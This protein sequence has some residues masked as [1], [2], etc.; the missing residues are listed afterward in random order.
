[1]TVITQLLSKDEQDLVQKAQKLAPKTSVGRELINNLL[2]RLENRGN[3]MVE[4]DGHYLKK[5]RVALPSNA[6]NP[7][8]R[9]L[10]IWAKPIVKSHNG[11]SYLLLKVESPSMMKD[12]IIRASDIFGD[13]INRI[14]LN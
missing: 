4:M 5:V 12:V 11:W 10:F 14:T 1:M 2:E 13:G 9:N 6:S 8:E 3:M 7:T